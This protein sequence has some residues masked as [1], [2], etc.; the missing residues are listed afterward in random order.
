MAQIMS[1]E[2][3]KSK[4]DGL[5]S[6]WKVMLHDSC[7]KLNGPITYQQSVKVKYPERNSARLKK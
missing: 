2:T 5:W 7:I 1:R 4:V 6:K 3:N